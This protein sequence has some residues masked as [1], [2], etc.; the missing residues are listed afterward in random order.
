LRLASLWIAVGW[1]LVASL[2]VASL[3]TVP[4]VSPGLGHLDKL[5][6]VV[7][8]VLVMTWFVQIWTSPR[9][10]L[11]HGCFLVLLGILLEVLQGWSD[12]R[13]ADGLDALANAFGVLLGMLASRTSVSSLL[14]RLEVRLFPA[15]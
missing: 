15:P 9:V 5:A 2:V 10:L 4:D 14:E 7:A 1:M 6:H 11:A 13:T 8:Y 12:R 3:A